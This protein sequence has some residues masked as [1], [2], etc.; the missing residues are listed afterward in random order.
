MDF[1]EWTDSMGLH[2]EDE[3]IGPMR[4]AWERATKIE[5]E[6][7]ATACSQVGQQPSSLWA[8]PGCW[9]HSA[10][11]CAEKIMERSN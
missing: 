9:T 11:V 3:I 10:Q 7:C 6:A 8:E 2:Y 4:L 5:R 1:E